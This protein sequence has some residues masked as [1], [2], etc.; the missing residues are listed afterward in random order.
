[1][2]AYNFTNF[3]LSFPSHRD[4]RWLSLNFSRQF[5]N[6]SGGAFRAFREMWSVRQCVANENFIYISHTGHSI[7]FHPGF[8]QILFKQCKRVYSRVFVGTSFSSLLYLKQTQI[9]SP[10]N[11]ISSSNYLVCYLSY[12]SFTSLKKKLFINFSFIVIFQKFNFEKQ[13]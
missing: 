9:N 13:N 5:W 8:P 6:S 7:Q 11:Y 10:V 12:I 3:F 1:M 4:Y 2:F